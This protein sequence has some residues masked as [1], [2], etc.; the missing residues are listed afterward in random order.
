MPETE[1]VSKVSQIEARAQKAYDADDRQWFYTAP[2]DHL[3]MLWGIACAAGAAYDDE[4]YDALD[5]RGWFD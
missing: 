4:V 2:L 1:F 3:T 5:Q